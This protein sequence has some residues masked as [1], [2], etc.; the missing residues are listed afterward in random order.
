MKD[1]HHETGFIDFNPTEL[2]SHCPHLVEIVTLLSPNSQLLNI[3]VEFIS[4]CLQTFL[5]GTLL[6]VYPPNF[7]WKEP[8][9]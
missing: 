6:L 3:L 8:Y 9:F 5:A 4:M 1:P 7:R 2:V